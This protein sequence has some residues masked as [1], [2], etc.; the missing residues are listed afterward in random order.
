MINSSTSKVVFVYFF[1]LPVLSGATLSIFWTY[2]HHFYQSSLV[3]LLL[4]LLF[5]FYG[6]RRGSLSFDGALFAIIVGHALTFANASF[7][8][9]LITF[10]LSSSKLTRYKSKEKLKTMGDEHIT[11]GKRNYMQVICNGAVPTLSAMGYTLFGGKGIFI[12]ENFPILYQDFISKWIPFKVTP[13]IFEFGVVASLAAACGDT[14]ASE[15][16]SAIGGKPRLIINPFKQVQE[17]TNGGVTV[18]GTI[19]SFLGGMAVGAAYLFADILSLI[20]KGYPTPFAPYIISSGTL[21]L[22]FG[23]I[24]FVGSLVDSIIGSIFQYSGIHVKT[25]QV[26]ENPTECKSRISGLNILNNNMVNLV[27]IAIVTL[28]YCSALQIYGY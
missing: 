5:S 11:G 6:F 24:G 19:A 14:W 7:F 25:G 22:K 8:F 3:A 26:S 17:G 10:F 12:D 18:I 4:A 23:L 1:L 16:G 21:I 27:S 28:V 20:H 13:D 15:V 9:C 2:Y